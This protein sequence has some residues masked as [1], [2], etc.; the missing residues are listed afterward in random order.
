M[1]V[2]FILVSALMLINTANAQEQTTWKLSGFKGKVKSRTTQRFSVINEMG[3]SQKGEIIDVEWGFNNIFV[4]Y[5]EKG[6]WTKYTSRKSDGSI[7]MEEIVTYAADNISSLS[8]H[9]YVFGVYNHKRVFT[10]DSKG[11]IVQARRYNS[12]DSLIP[13]SFMSK[14]K[15]KM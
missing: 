12:A 8:T 1:K 10:T 11:N 15:I 6:Y 5:N 9:Y 3:H 2:L 14:M 13:Y 4:T 7:I